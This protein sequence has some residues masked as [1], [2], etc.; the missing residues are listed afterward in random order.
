MTDTITNSLLSQKLPAVPRVKIRKCI[1]TSEKRPCIYFSDIAIIDGIKDRDIRVINYLYKK[2]FNQIGFMVSSN[3]GTKMD[4]EDLFQ[5]ALVMIYQ[6][7]I[8]DSL[9]LT[10]SFNTY[11][12]SICWHLWLQKLNK[13]AF[14]YQYKGMT[15]LDAVE[16][17]MNIKEILEESEKYKLFQQHFLKLTQA[18]QNVLRL[19]MSKTPAKEVANI[20]GYKSDDYAKFR[21]YL[22]KEKLKNSIINDPQFKKLCQS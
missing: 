19:Y 20:M 8:T 9:Q 22:C 5:D 13:H 12:Y 3:S 17:E 7:I 14:K 18:E 1:K 15:D 21:K 16:D 4:A 11:L 2:F 6:K 10:S